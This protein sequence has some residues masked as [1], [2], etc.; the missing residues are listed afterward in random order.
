MF[1][2]F[3]PQ[4][5]VT[6]T[7]S[8]SPD[9]SAGDVVGGIMTIPAAI[10][11][12]GTA[13]LKNLT[14]RDS[15]NQKPDLYILLFNALPTGTYTDNAAFAWGSDD[16]A[17]CIGYVMIGA[18]DYLTLDSKAIGFADFTRLVK[19]AENEN[20]GSRALYA[21]AVAVGTIN[22]ASTSDLTFLFG[23]LPD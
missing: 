7:V 6:P 10:R 20:P 5:A 16:F 21:I 4:I 23:L 9:Y 2:P 19:V 15:S 1:Q 18:T 3:S 14:I 12:T 17:K 11:D 8:A 13:I 22:L